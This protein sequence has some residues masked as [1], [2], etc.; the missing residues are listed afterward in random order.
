VP[1]VPVR[2][3]NLDKVLHP[4]WK[5]PKRGPVTISFGA[6]MR[7]EGEDYVSLARQ[8]EDAVRALEVRP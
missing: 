7:L 6:P 2:L 4:R 5:W 3:D 1:V 8:V